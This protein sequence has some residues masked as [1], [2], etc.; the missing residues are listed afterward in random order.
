[1]KVFSRPTPAEERWLAAAAAT[2]TT[3]P[4]AVSAER[5]GGWR[6]TGTLARIALFVLGLVAAALLFG[7]MGFGTG[8]VT[9]LFAGLIAAFAA[10]SLAASKRLFASGIEEGLCL[11]G[12]LLLGGW[13]V[14]VLD[15][16]PGLG[17]ETIVTPVMIAV[18]GAAGLRLLNPFITTVAAISFVR[19]V[20]WS[21]ADWPVAGGA[22]TTGLVTLLFGCAL[23]A[24]ALW[25]GGRTWQR[26]SH[27]RML[28]WLVAALPIA[29]YAQLSFWMQL[30]LSNEARMASG[31]LWP[32]LV[33][34]VLGA[35]MLWT[36]LRRR[37]HAPL[38][39]FMGCVV[40]IAVELRF[41][42]GFSTETWLIGYGLAA[43]VVGVALDRYLR[44]PRNGVTSAPLSSREGPLDLLQTAGA[45]AL[46][47]RATIDVP[48]AESGMT[49]GGGRFGGG[50]ASG[51]Y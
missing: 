37:R 5:T 44:E 40:C 11:G 39:G 42:A 43:L 50:G 4:P 18:A 28:D 27:D 12:W 20:G 31:R 7:I 24:L 1:M 10:E 33:L 19:W 13:V 9:L 23:A 41:A 14:S 34:A 6:S 49:G 22:A 3:S 32:V 16:M 46:A 51:S 48:T 26:P 38:L 30:D 2:A 8:T 47:P 35:A 25:L 36:G 15:S 21:S 17:V 29:S 45:A